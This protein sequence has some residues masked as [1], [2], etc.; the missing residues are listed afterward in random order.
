MRP[1]GHAT[2]K[3]EATVRGGFSVPQAFGRFLLAAAG[4]VVIGVATA[5]AVRAVRSLID[6]PIVL[7][8]LSLGTPFMAYLVGQELHVSGV[9]AVVVTGLMVGHD[10]PRAVSG[11]SRLQTAAVWRLVDFLLEGFVFLLIGQQ[12]PDVWNGLGDYDSSTVVIAAAVSLGTVLLVR[13]LW[14]LLMQQLPRAIRLRGGDPGVPGDNGLSKKELL[15]LSW[16]GTRGVISLAAI[17]S[18]PL[19][20]HSGAR[21]PSG[22]CSSSAHSSWCS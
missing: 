4:G 21:S 11:A 19:T 18:L 5:Y 14:L 20:T 13:P 10:T 7:N 6:E 22:T 1:H 3:V 17:F 16:A 12:L 9:L 8:V 2:V 15:L